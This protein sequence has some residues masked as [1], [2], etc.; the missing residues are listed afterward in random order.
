ML[1]KILHCRI[2]EPDARCFRQQAVEQVEHAVLDKKRTEIADQADGHD[3][4]Q[5]TK[6]VIPDIDLSI[7][8]FLRKNGKQAV[9]GR[10]DPVN[11]IQRDG[12]G[13][14]DE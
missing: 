12:D 8:A 5:K 2:N 14:D 7:F 10:N 13:R 6:A 4:D 1:Q 11:S 3:D 9:D